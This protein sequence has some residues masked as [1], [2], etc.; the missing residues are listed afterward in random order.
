MLAPQ[1]GASR[2][3]PPDRA[4]P[5]A[6][7]PRRRRRRAEV[8]GARRV[9]ATTTTSPSRSGRR[10]PAARSSAMRNRSSRSCAR[11]A[12]AS[13]RPEI[14]YAA[15]PS[16]GDGV[17]RKWVS[18][19]RARAGRLH[20]RHAVPL[21]LVLGHGRL[22]ERGSQGH[23]NAVEPGQRRARR[24]APTASATCRTRPRLARR[25][26]RRDIRLSGPGSTGNVNVTLDA[27][28]EPG[29]RQ[30]LDDAARL[31]GR[32]H[33]PRRAGRRARSPDLSGR[34]R[35]LRLQT[36]RSRCARS[37]AA[38]ATRRRPSARRCCTRSATCSASG[39]R[40]TTGDSAGRREHPQH[41]D[42]GGLESRGDALG[43]RA[44]P[45]PTRP[46]PTTSR[47][48]SIYYG[49]AAVGAA[50]GRELH[51]CA[52]GADGGL[53]GHVHRHFDRRA[54]RLELGLRRLH[55]SGTITRRRRTRRHTSSRSR[56][57][58]R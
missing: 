55:V 18:I 38:P 29:R 21:P 39:T 1:P 23:R 20:G 26:A 19:A 14:A 53:A 42:R 33:R 44:R 16:D 58:T 57:P 10:P 27:T 2:T 34:R 52:V 51:L 36:G 24:A 17:R 49:T 43:H 8:R 3:V 31:L 5:F 47:R 35:P 7:R 4:R 22:A 12:A 32:R 46:R 25:A 6:V 11:S 30:R 50:P 56:G 54:D 15:P 48:S 13:R 41:D 40:T 28:T 9:L 45:S 37:R